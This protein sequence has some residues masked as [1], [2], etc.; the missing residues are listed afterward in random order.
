MFRL[1][2]RKSEETYIHFLVG[3]KAVLDKAPGWAQSVFV[4]GDS[5]MSE[6]GIDQFAIWHSAG[7]EPSIVQPVGVISKPGYHFFLLRRTFFSPQDELGVKRIKE[8]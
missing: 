5:G 3:W 7:V 4:L 8:N 1:H 6:T 2:E